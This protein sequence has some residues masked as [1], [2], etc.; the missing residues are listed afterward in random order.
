MIRKTTLLSRTKR[1][2]NTNPIEEIESTRRKEKKK[3]DSKKR[4]KDRSSSRDDK[5]KKKKDSD[6]NDKDDDGPPVFGKY[7][8]IKLSDLPQ[9]QRSF[10]VWLEEVKGVG[11]FNGPKWELQNYFKE[12]AED[13]NTATMPHKKYYDYEKWEM[14]EYQ[15]QK[16]KA[17][18]ALS[19]SSSA[20]CK[21]ALHIE[22]QREAMRN[23]QKEGLNLVR[24]MMSKEKIEEMKRKKQLQAEMEHAFKTGDRANY[25]RL[26]KRL[27]P[28]EK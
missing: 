13:Y 14:E 17:A 5:K 22:K 21:E 9:K 11:G 12:F 8:L 24:S 18:A 28:E 10:E 23:K 15:K 16:A 4:K 2:E 26:Q 20:Q 6:S 27:E 3:K 7:G 1:D 19:S 25:R